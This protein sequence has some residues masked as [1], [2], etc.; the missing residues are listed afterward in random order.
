VCRPTGS[1]LSPATHPRYSAA[2]MINWWFLALWV[3]LCLTLANSPAVVETPSVE[4][5]PTPFLGEA[6]FIYPVAR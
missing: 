6:R 3:P 4:G 5:D 2:A 1:P